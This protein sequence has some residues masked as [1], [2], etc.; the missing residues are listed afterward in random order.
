M[1]VR[2]HLVGLFLGLAVAAGATQG[3]QPL[4]IVVPFAAGGGTDQYAR[5]VS[6]TAFAIIRRTVQGA[7]RRT[8]HVR[9]KTQGVGVIA[10]EFRAR[11]TPFKRTLLAQLLVDRV[12]GVFLRSAQERPFTSFRFCPFAD[13]RP[14]NE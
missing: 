13:M 10:F 9:R 14:I 2:R 1:R 11:L 7:L 4:R 8:P 3:Q 12:I 5:L 6:K